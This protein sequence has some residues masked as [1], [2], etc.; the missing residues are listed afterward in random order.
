MSHTEETNAITP[1]NASSQ[2]L[3]SKEDNLLLQNAEIYLLHEATL[4]DLL[5]TKNYAVQHLLYERNELL[6]EQ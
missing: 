6:R 4:Q 3:S 1:D 2:H 5:R